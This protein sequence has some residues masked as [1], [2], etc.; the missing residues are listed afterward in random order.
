[1]IRNKLFS[2]SIKNLS[3]TDTT[4]SKLNKIIYL[5]HNAIDSHI[6]TSNLQNLN[7]SNNDKFFKN[8][9]NHSSKSNNN[10]NNNNNNNLNKDL[11]NKKAN[12]G[13]TIRYLIENLPNS[14]NSTI[15]SNKL[16]NDI[17]LRILP[18][19]H[20]NIPIFKGL[21][22]YLTTIKTL[23]LILTTF[24]INKNVKLHLSSI[25]ILEN[26]E[27]SLLNNN[28][29]INLSNGILIENEINKNINGGLV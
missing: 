13:S 17:I 29:L 15:D 8:L 12:L 18:R 16:S 28:E 1:M 23:Q 2:K 9:M 6:T 25:K 10:N 19:S 22:V 26:N 20:P 27:N 3:I 21:I 5:N 24:F 4:I 7:Q 11:I 14:L